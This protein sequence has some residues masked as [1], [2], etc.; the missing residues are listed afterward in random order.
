M[1]CE[2]NRAFL[3]SA[4]RLVVLADHTKWG[5]IGLSTIADLRDADV[6]IS[7]A[8]LPRGAR[9]VLGERVERLVVAK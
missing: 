3:Q 8:S 1:E 5:V 6:L 9:E 4:R 7:D 2:I